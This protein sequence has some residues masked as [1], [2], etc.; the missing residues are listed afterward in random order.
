MVAVKASVYTPSMQMGNLREAEVREAR[1]NCVSDEFRSP[2]LY[3][4]IF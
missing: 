3:M 1:N 4:T 2:Y